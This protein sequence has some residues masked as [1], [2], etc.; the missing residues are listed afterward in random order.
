VVN[1]PA[2]ES[3][4]IA[5][6]EWASVCDALFGGRQ[7]IILRKGGIREASAPGVFV[8]EHSEFWLYPT[9][10]H[11][12]EQGV[13]EHPADFAAHPRTPGDR[14]VPIRALIRVDLMSYVEDERR[15]AAL[16]SHHVLTAETVLKRFHYRKPGLWVLGARVWRH[17]PGYSIA[18]TPE[19]A[20]CKTWVTLEEAL[21]TAGLT[22][23]LDT[24][25]WAAERASLEADVREAL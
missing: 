22:V 1:Q 7:T 19:Y 8:P 15:L 2:A 3:C 4:G 24:A 6:K 10:V 21:S 17:E 18:V 11:Q 25:A 20:G 23:V 5:F 16:E 14:S 12:A 13:R 9:W